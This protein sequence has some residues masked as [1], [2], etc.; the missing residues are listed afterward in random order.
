MDIHFFDKAQLLDLEHDNVGQEEHAEDLELEGIDV[1]IWEKKNR[2]C[3][4]PQEHILEV[5]CQ[6]HDSEVAEDWGQY[7]TKELVLR[8]FI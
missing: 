8:N 4:V 2:L 5:L 6:H 3:I 1:A 7:R